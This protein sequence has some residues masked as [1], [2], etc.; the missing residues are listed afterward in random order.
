MRIVL[1]LLSTFGS[2]YV[3]LGPAAA[4]QRQDLA[5]EIAEFK[6]TV[7]AAREAEISPR[8]DGLLRRIHFSPGQIVEEGDLVFEFEPAGK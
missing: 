6:G 4:Q 7:V 3:L 8:F 5:S 1:S 2:I